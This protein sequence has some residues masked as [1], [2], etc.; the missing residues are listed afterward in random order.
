VT[1]LWSIERVLELVEGDR[2]LIEQLYVSGLCERRSEGFLPNEVEVVR[3]AR[4]LARDLDVNWPGVEIIL[5]LRDELVATQRQVADLLELV[6]RAK[7][8]HAGN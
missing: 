1:E 4:V 7:A 2:E 6:R 3:V 8:D 5:H